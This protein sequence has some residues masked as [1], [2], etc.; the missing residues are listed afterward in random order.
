[1]DAINS[2][3]TLVVFTGN[4]NEDI[5]LV[6]AGANLISWPYLKYGDNTAVTINANGQRSVVISNSSHILQGFTIKNSG[7][8]A[9]DKWGVAMMGLKCSSNIIANNIIN[10]ET[11]HLQFGIMFPQQVNYSNLIMS[12][13]IRGIRY[14]S[15]HIKSASSVW[16]YRN[17][18]INS[19]QR[20][21]RIWNTSTDIRI[22]NN[23]I[24]NHPQVGIV[25]ETSSGG[26][27]K[28]NIIGKTWAPGDGGKEGGLCDH[29]GGDL[30]VD[31]NVFYSNSRGNVVSN[32]LGGSFSFGDSNKTGL[33]PHIKED[34]LFFITNT[35]S[36][37]WNTALTNLPTT[38]PG[39]W[40]DSM[41]D[42]GWIEGSFNYGPNIVAPV[43]DTYVQ[44]SIIIQGYV[45][46]GSLP[47]VAVYMS[48]QAG[49]WEEVSLNASLHWWTNN[50]DTLNLND[51]PVSSEFIAVDSSG[52]T[53]GPN[54][55]LFTVDNSPPLVDII[56]PVS[57]AVLSDNV[58]INGISHEPHSF[59][60]GGALHF[61]NQSTGTVTSYA[62]GAASNWNYTFD[63]SLL[64]DGSYILRASAANVFSNIPFLTGF[65]KKLPVT[66]ANWQ[67]SLAETNTADNA[68]L[69]GHHIMAG[70]AT[71]PQP[72]FGLPDV[73]MRIN[74]GPYILLDSFT[75]WHTN[76][77]TTVYTDG[78][79]IFTFTA[80]S[81]FFSSNSFN[82]QVIID[83]SAPV[84][85]VSSPL[86]GA[87]K[88]EGYTIIFTADDDYS[89]LGGTGR[90][91]ITSAAGFIIYQTNFISW[92]AF[93]KEIEH[94]TFSNGEYTLIICVTNELGLAATNITLFGINNLDF[95]P[96][97]G[98]NPYY[99]SRGTG[100]YIQ[101]ITLDSVITIYSVNGKMVRELKP[102]QDPAF[103][104][105][106]E[107][108]GDNAAGEPAASGIYIY[109]IRNLQAVRTGKITVC[110]EY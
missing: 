24:W 36:A 29:T 43:A 96:V 8:A 18:I 39:S 60:T 84:I 37:A 48:N 38:P 85:E 26:S 2:N 107:W 101:N 68:L 88:K 44:G 41:P 30:E 51:G 28:N 46:E 14:D 49:G 110:H 67:P 3:E 78:T 40:L 50:Y 45:M 15:I 4:Y 10:G 13:I 93:S 69:N 79:N 11:N 54:S 34:S 32:H 95:N 72:S 91:T 102:P 92:G 59:L 97:L 31:Y 64:A 22:Y 58:S 94:D 74:Q 17:L 61:S 98:P 73:Y 86:S 82:R 62:L 109:F 33:S 66:I 25:F 83:N 57:N 16:I 1:M 56:S 106:L 71:N 5:V 75:N 80:V 81:S 104:G 47:T 12:N 100:F 70:Y 9:G 99:S 63:T 76:I 23:T 108:K 42:I 65:S 21:F 77:D 35:N 27:V 87:I 52:S 7:V 20:G 90:V 6:A 19:G 103:T 55:L 105:Y 53:N 89:E